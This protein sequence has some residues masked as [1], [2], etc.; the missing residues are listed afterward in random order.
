[1]DSELAKT[2]AAVEAA[3]AEAAIAANPGMR[4]VG[5]AAAGG[6]VDPASGAADDETGG[7][8]AGAPPTQ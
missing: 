5:P 2:N 1:M 8:A 4:G 3:I 6:P 7:P